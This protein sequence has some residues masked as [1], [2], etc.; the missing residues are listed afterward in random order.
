MKPIRGLFLI[1]M[2]GFYGMPLSVNAQDYPETFKLPDSVSGEA[3]QANIE[4][5]L[6]DEYRVRIE[7]AASSSI[8]QWAFLDGDMPSGLTLRT[9]GLIV[10]IPNAS[11]TQTLRFRAKVFDVS[12]RNSEP[13]VVCF[14]LSTRV[15]RL[16]LTKLTPTLSFTKEEGSANSDSEGSQ[17]VTIGERVSNEAMNQR[18]ARSPV[19]RTTSRVAFDDASGTSAVVQNPSCAGCDRTSCPTCVPQTNDSKKTILI[20]AR[21]GSVTGSRKYKKGEHAQ[22]LIINKNPYIRTYTTKID[23][24]TVEETALNTFLPLLGTII[25]DQL[26]EAPKEKVNNADAAEAQKATPDPACPNGS[27][28]DFLKALKDR[29]VAQESSLKDSYDALAVRHK[30]VAVNYKT[31]VAS[32]SNP[33]ASCQILYCTSFSLHSQL[34]QRVGD[35]SIKDVQDVS[36]GLKNLANTLKQETEL[37]RRKYPTCS[38]QVLNEYGVLADGLLSRANEVETN[39]GKVK[40]DN[41]KFEKALDAIDRATGDSR[42]FAEA[43]EIP[44]KRSTDIVERVGRGG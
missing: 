43:H 12:E 20:D 22:I 19:H 38:S 1:L 37:M 8:L 28:I 10:G 35:A 4:R 9:N 5:V 30:V 31:G 15:P 27:E 34:E 14:S 36:E 18:S 33:Q 41:K 21:A 25:A 13:L 23:E 17:T 29:A 2:I 44:Q 11:E 42:N 26:K 39:L 24:K 40:A 6:R 32:L 7:T 3:Y 16:R